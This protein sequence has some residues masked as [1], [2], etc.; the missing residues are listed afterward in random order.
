VVA[1]A[2]A[3][4]AV[5]SVRADVLPG[6]DDHEFALELLETEGVLIVPGRGFNIR[7]ASHFRTTLLPPP[8]QV[9]EVFARIERCLASMAATRQ[10]HVA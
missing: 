10:R 8:A 4:Y 9:R 6:F 7:P 1:P 3:L 5:P 2:G